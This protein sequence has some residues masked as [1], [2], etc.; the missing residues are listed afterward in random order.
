MKLVLTC[1]LCISIPKTGKDTSVNR[2]NHLMAQNLSV[3][4]SCC[5]NIP[6]FGSSLLVKHQML[7]PAIFLSLLR[8]LSWELEEVA[9]AG[10]QDEGLSQQARLA[11]ALRE[12]GGWSVECLRQTKSIFN[13]YYKSPVPDSSNLVEAKLFRVKVSIDND[14]WWHKLQS[15]RDEQILFSV[16]F[17]WTSSAWNKEPS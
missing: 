5:S 2:R 12:G 13:I 1:N 16:S 14:D 15:F 4:A 3:P 10:V 6:S 11:P 17:T 8:F 9:G 7:I